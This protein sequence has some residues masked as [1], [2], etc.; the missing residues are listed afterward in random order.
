AAQIVIGTAA[1]EIQA[2]APETGTV[3]RTLQSKGAPIHGLAFADLNGDSILDYAFALSNTLAVH[4]GRTGRLA[5]SS[6]PIGSRSDGHDWDAMGAND[7]LHI[8]DVDD[9]GR[10]DLVVNLGMGF[11]V[12]SFPRGLVA[13][14]VT[15]D[16]RSDLAAEVPV[17]LSHPS[18]VPVSVRFATVD[19]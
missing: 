17:T 6:G 12:Y 4:D 13:R 16:P 9:D 2:L 1:G 7:S 10:P 14:D 5:W 3:L 18:R 11:Q 8:A 19:G 15:A